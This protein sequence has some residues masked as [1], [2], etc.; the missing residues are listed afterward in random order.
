MN[1]FAIAFGITWGPI[2]WPMLN[3]LFDTAPADDRRCRSTAL[4]WLINWLV[5]RTFPL[6]ADVG[7]DGVRV[8]RRF[9]GNRLCIRLAYPPGNPGRGCAKDQQRTSTMRA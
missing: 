7:L 6:L 4:N 9:R 8:V 3:E 5:V 2:M 1:L